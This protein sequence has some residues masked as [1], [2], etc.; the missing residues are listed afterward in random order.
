MRKNQAEPKNRPKTKTVSAVA[1]KTK[2]ETA[3][4]AQAPSPSSPEGK[5]QLAVLPTP[6]NILLIKAF[7][8]NV[9]GAEADMG[10]MIEMLE[11]YVKRVAKND[12]SSLEAMLVGQASALQ[13]IFTSLALRAS[14]A[15]DL[16]KYQAFMSLALKAQSQSRSTISAVVELK[17]PR[18]TTFV[19]QNNVANGPQQINNVVHAAPREEETPKPPNQLSGEVH[20]LRQ[21]PTAQGLTGGADQT[22]EAMGAVNRAKVRRRKE[23]IRPQGF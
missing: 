19:G 4:S 22:L 10:Q 8:A 16:T 9:M 20:E 5:G 2:L 11:F 14:R 23:A 17:H 6:S 12:L 21:N 1:E 3:K 7:Q 18:Q 13:T 15:E